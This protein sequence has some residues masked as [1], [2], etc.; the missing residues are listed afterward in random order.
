VT[1]RLVLVL[2][3]T[4]S[5]KS[6][7]ATRRA[8]E[9]AAA[10][11]DGAP[12]VYLATARPGDPELDRRIERHRRDRPTDW[13]TIEVGAELA[14]AIAS[15]PATATILLDGLTLWL[16][17]L[18]DDPPDGDALVAGPVADALEAIAARPGPTVVVS[19][20]ISLGV[21]PMTPLGRAFVDALGLA[22]QAFAAR[23]D[24]VHLMVAGL[25]LTLLDRARR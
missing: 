16:S 8:A 25:P 23:A 18:G 7:F 1:A 13:P 3:G 20:E 2:G 10:A 15:A 4:K 21:I 19:D 12:V 9:L 14:A 24:E 17:G 22:H 5:G 6:R 11:S